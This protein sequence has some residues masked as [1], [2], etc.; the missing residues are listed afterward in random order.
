MSFSISAA[1]WVYAQTRMLDQIKNLEGIWI[2]EDYMNNFNITKSSIK[3]EEAFDPNDPVGLRINLSE[4]NDGFL[5]IGY[6]RL[7]DHLIHPEIS[8]YTIIGTD[9]IHEQ[10]HFNINI[11]KSDSFIL[12]E[13][14]EFHYSDYEN[15]AFLSLLF[16]P[17][18]LITLH[19]PPTERDGKKSIRFKRVCHSFSEDYPFPNPLYYYNRS[20][21]LVGS[22][23]LI[24]DSG[25]AVSEDF[26]IDFDGKAYGYLPFKDKIF[27]FSTDIYCGPKATEDIIDLCSF[28]GNLEPECEVFIYKRIDD[29]TIQLHSSEWVEISDGDEKQV[30][31]NMIYTLVKNN[32]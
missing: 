20:K 13:V 23:T 27:Y 6:S 10:G 30:I 8:K 26:K 9:T 29:K 31:G 2:A 19:I 16:S 1:G 24:N 11:D 22:Y 7:H 12:H 15:K 17:D 32:Y 18:T 4:I 14:S 25:K 21:T 5:N 3:S 28:N